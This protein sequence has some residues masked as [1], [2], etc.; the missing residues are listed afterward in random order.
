MKLRINPIVADLQIVKTKQE[1][2]LTIGFVGL[3]FCPYQAE[4]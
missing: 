2:R 3:F 1:N 4:N